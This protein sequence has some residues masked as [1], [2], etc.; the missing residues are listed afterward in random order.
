MKVATIGFSLLLAARAH[1]APQEILVFAAASTADA[2][3]QI[4]ARFESRSGARVGFSFGGSND[5]ARQIL[6][7]APAD[8]FLSADREQMDRVVA[9]GLVRREAVRPL[10]SNQLV[11]IVPRGSKR[12]IES[13][14]D[15]RAA[16]TLALA[17]PAAVPAGVYARHW[18]EAIGLWPALEAKV[19]PTLD[20]R[21][22]L[23]AVE[24]ENAAAAVV[25]RTDAAISGRVRVVYEVPRSQGPAI[26]YPVAALARAGQPAA[27]ALIEFMT[28]PQSRGIFA[29]Y[30][31]IVL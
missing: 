31:F 8:L 16:P 4:A 2:L 11:V 6:A 9:A 25:Y 27:A 3:Q 19:I 22:A 15:L 13:P 24:T 29:R 5:L 21:A 17:D 1:P 10:L 12:K 18:L 14:E 28:G 7:G 23:A 26:V 20:V 30:G